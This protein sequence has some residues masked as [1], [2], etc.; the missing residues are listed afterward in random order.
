[1]VEGLGKWDR[2]VSPDENP[3]EMHTLLLIYAG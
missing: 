1:M 3:I 2:K